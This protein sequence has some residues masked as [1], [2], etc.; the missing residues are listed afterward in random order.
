[1]RNRN[2]VAIITLIIIIAILVA[3]AGAFLYFIL[4][5][6]GIVTK[7]LKMDTETT[8]SEVRT[9]LQ[10]LINIELRSASSDIAGT[11]DDISTRFN[12]PRLI[13]FLS[14]NRNY[15]GTEHDETNVV[16]C[17][18]D[19]EGSSDI[20]PKAGD[21][22]IKDKYRVIIKELCTESDKYGTGKKIEDG[23]IFTLEAKVEKQTQEDGT[24][25]TVSTGEFEL[26]YYDKNGNSTVLET[27]LLYQ[28]KQS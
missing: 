14:G 6:D 1:M 5:D 15:N 21:G 3:L 11:T 23:D 22:T 2:G 27:F 26:K 16:K 20:F 25:K 12:E 19:I 28:T 13:N 8:E 17:I 24:E 18:E 7:T 10:S 9:H 4:K